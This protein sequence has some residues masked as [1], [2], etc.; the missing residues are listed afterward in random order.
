MDILELLDK[1]SEVDLELINR[2]LHQYA[3]KIEVRGMPRS[4]LVIFEKDTKFDTAIQE[5]V[6]YFIMKCL[7][8]E[9]NSGNT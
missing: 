4:A 5:T 1:T 2:S 3:I 7:E 8:K 9:V 6:N